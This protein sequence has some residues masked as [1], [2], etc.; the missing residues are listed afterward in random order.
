MQRYLP[1]Q[2]RVARSEL[3]RGLEQ[4]GSCPGFVARW[5]RGDSVNTLMALG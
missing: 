1:A 3:V 2:L 5:L 4:H